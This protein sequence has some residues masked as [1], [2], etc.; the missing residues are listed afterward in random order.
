MFFFAHPLHPLHLCSFLPILS[1]LSIYVLFCP[2]CQS[3]S[4][5]DTYTKRTGYIAVSCPFCAL[6]DTIMEQ[7][8]G[9]LSQGDRLAVPSV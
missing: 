5:I 6:T 1:I 9:S 3:M 8:L 7:S 4:L 2:S